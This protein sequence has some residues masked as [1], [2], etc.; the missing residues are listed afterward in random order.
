MIWDLNVSCSRAL[1]TTV[2]RNYNGDP[3]R[4]AKNPKPTRVF[5]YQTPWWMSSVAALRGRRVGE[6]VEA[7]DVGYPRLI[8]PTLS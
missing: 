4:Y 1:S 6:P 3:H 5:G 8:T 7:A 2:S